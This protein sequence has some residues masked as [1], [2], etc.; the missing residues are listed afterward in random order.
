[1]TRSRRI[2]IPTRSPDVAPV[3]PSP[4][5]AQRRPH[6]RVSHP[7]SRPRLPTSSRVER[8]LRIASIGYGRIAAATCVLHR[9][10]GLAGRYRIVVINEPS[11]DLASITPPDPLD[12][13]HG[14]FSGREWDRK[15]T[16][17]DQDGM[18]SR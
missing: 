6:L 18:R 13:T 8:P 2:L 5:C 15:G 17:S 16:R 12:S 9:G 1:M 3:R 11:A 4:A 14:R 7:A 10:V